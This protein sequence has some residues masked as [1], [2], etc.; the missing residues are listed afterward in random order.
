M[1]VWHDLFLRI[2]CHFKAKLAKHAHVCLSNKTTWSFNDDIKLHPHD[3]R[4]PTKYITRGFYLAQCHSVEFV[5][6]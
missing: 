5:L 1:L 2:G 6:K 4:K 3:K